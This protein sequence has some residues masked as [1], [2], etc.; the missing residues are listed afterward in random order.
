MHCRAR[1]STSFGGSHKVS[2][3]SEL[4]KIGSLEDNVT[5]ESL[6]S[7]IF[8]QT[9]FL[10]LEST[11][12]HF[13]VLNKES[14]I[15]YRRKEIEGKDVVT[16]LECVRKDVLKENKIPGRVICE[17]RSLEELR[18]EDRPV[19]NSSKKEESH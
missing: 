2:T 17:N 14:E 9:L 12:I 15:Q 10:A 7:G 19:E 1:T 16:F 11:K 6:S 3:Y 4:L 8:M 18:N 5:I 13:W